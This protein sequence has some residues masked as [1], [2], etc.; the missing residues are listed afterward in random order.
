MWS[1]FIQL[2]KI[3][4]F[5]GSILCLIFIPWIIAQSSN[6]LSGCKCSI[7]TNTN[8]NN[9]EDTNNSNELN[10]VAVICC[11]INQTR[12]SQFITNDYPSD[13]KH[14]G[15]DIINDYTTTTT[16][17][18]NNDGIVWPNHTLCLP[19]WRQLK[20]QLTEN[21]WPSLLVSS[22]SSSSNHIK[23]R[24]QSK[25]I[26]ELE[27]LAIVGQSNVYDGLIQLDSNEFRHY[28]FTIPTTISTTSTTSNHYTLKLLRF[29]IEQTSLRII[30]QGFFDEI[31]ANNLIHLEIR[32][33][34]NLTD[35]GLHIGWLANLNQLQSLD[36]SLNQFYQINLASWGIPKHYRTLS[37]LDLS[38]NHLIH[39]NDYTFIRLTNL[40]YLNLANNYLIS[41]SSNVFYG[42]SYLKVL[43]L[44]GNQ[45]RMHSL[46]LT[47]PNF[48]TI[49]PNLKQLILSRN[50]LAIPLS[51]NNTSQLSSSASTS[52]PPS[53]SL[54]SSTIWWF[55]NSCPKLLTTIY[56]ENIDSISYHRNQSTLLKLPL[57]DWN[58]C[59][60]LTDV[61]LNHNENWLKCIDYNWLNN[62]RFRIHP[63]TLQLCPI[64]IDDN[65]NNSQSKLI[66][67]HDV[68][69]K[70]NR[71]PDTINSTTSTSTSVVVVVVVVIHHYLVQHM[72]ELH[73][74]QLILFIGL[75]PIKI[76]Y[77]L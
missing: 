39:L 15:F 43:N 70:S 41:L 42:L 7:N 53:S 27:R 32:R 63:S 12:L 29:T 1:F 18:N 49:L 61:Y 23:Q 52:P 6:C 35:Y 21:S 46:I 10:T 71:L 17:N 48:N 22:S 38:G 77:M 36:L 8:N 55:T 37:N 50:P 60:S 20:I 34:Y 14:C 19:L 62:N 40:M 69:T 33:N 73:Q 74:Y 31:H 68:V 65:N 72:Y 51:L 44:Q 13:I 26:L 30:S 4:Q 76:V 56:L 67:N 59:D 45:L 9:N 2:I 11:L 54:S 5:N 64:S 24:I 66:T 16:N 75:F 58:Y 57:F 47:V 28:F 3:L 25:C